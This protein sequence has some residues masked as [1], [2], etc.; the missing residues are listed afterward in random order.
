MPIKVA[1]IPEAVQQIP[2]K[3]YP[4]QVAAYCRVS[5]KNEEQMQSLEAQI[6]YYTLYPKPSQL[7][8]DRSVF[9]YCVRYSHESASR[10]PTASKRLHQQKSRFDSGEVPQPLWPGRIGNHPAN[11]E[12]KEHEHWTSHSY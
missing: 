2:V 10:L 5:T 6:D 11:Q 12:V 4:L 7:D 9:R 3:G 8:T 1:K